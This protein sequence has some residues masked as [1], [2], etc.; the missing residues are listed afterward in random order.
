MTT[1]VLLVT[2]AVVVTWLVRQ[3][4]TL[5]VRDETDRFARVQS[6]VAGWTEDARAQSRNDLGSGR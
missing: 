1:F 6:V 5:D 4:A 2:S 3:A